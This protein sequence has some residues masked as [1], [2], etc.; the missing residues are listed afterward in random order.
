M[1]I[2]KENKLKLQIEYFYVTEI[3][4]LKEERRRRGSNL[5]P[6]DKAREGKQTCTL[7]MLVVVTIFIHT[8]LPF[9]REC[10]SF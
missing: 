3:I 10:T 5:R 9:P 2:R 8:I 7:A 4:F 1:L 6:P